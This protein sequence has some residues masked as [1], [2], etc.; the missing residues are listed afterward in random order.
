MKQFK[1]PD[2]NDFLSVKYQCSCGW[3]DNQIYN[4]YQCQY[5]EMHVRCNN[6]GTIS[7]QTRGNNWYCRDHHD[8]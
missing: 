5:V 3:R 2:C 8:K 6:I 7:K 4:P 1:C